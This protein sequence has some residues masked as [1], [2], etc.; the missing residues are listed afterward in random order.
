[1]PAQD[2]VVDVRRGVAAAAVV[3]GKQLCERDSLAQHEHSQDT[4]RNKQHTHLLHHR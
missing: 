1:M 3:V 2:L 4:P